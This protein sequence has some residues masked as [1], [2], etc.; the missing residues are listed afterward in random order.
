MGQSKLESFIEA[1]T[2]TVVGFII[3]AIIQYLVFKYYGIHLDLVS[4]FIIISTFTVAS[5][6]RS[7]IIRRVFNRLRIK[8][9]N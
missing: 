9:V 5:V 6:L 8:N 4:N 1:I 2:N 3:S 7:Y